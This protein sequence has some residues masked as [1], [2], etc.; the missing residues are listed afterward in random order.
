MHRVGTWAGLAGMLAGVFAVV[1]ASGRVVGAQ[2]L[3]RLRG[4][5]GVEAYLAMQ[6][7]RR[8]GPVFVSGAISPLWAA[9]SRSLTYWSG[10]KHH[11]FD[12]D[13]R[14]DTVVPDGAGPDAGSV[15]AGGGAGDPVPTRPVPLPCPITIVDRGRQRPCEGSPDL[16]RRAYSRDR[17]LYI[18]AADGSGEV[19]VTTDGSEAGRVKYG[20]ASWVYGEE[21]DQ[22]T[23]I[24]WS[25]DSSKVAFYRFDE[26]RVQDYFLALDQTRLQTR[27]DVEAYPK[28]GTANPVVDVLVYD[29]ATH[30]TVRL[31]VRD[32]QPFSDAVVGHYVYGVTWSAD[33]REVRLFRTDRRQQHWEYAGCS[34][35]SGR[36]RVIA[37]EVSTTGWVENRPTMRRLADGHRFLLASERT[38]WRNY[39]LYDDRRGFIGPVTQLAGSEAGDI[40]RVDEA[41]GRLYYMARDGDDFLKLQLHRVGLD[42]RDDV[43]LTDPRCTH[44]VTLAPDGRSFVD[45]YQTHAAA[46][47]SRVVDMDGHVIAELAHSDLSRFD[48]LGLRPVEQFPYVAGDGRTHLFGTIS[49]PSGYDP[50]RRYP[51]LVSVYAGPEST[52]GV[53]SETFTPPSSM[54]E[55]GFLVVTFGTRAQPGLGRRTLDALYLHLGQTEI[56]DLAAGVRVLRQRPDVEP[57]RIGIYGTSYGGYAALMALLRYPNLFAA[58]SVS[59]APTDWRQYDTIYTERYMWTPQGNEAGYEAA[60]ALTYAGNLRGRLLIY[61]GTADNNVHPGNSLDLM[62]ALNRAGKSY[63][64]QIGPDQEHSSVP[65]E[66]MMEFFLENLVVRPDR[67]FATPGDAPVARAVSHP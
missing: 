63:E 36:C 16:T 57:D 35:A 56:D 1:T 19:A 34:P 2:T 18:S 39:D 37:R 61:Y 11:R 59:S 27:V 65:T 43:R 42:G 50:A 48:A 22:T 40:V 26:S 21:L 13:T 51:V 9:D 45:V 62:E 31:D 38:G 10:G 8:D 54:S 44:D 24:W 47:A 55:Y 46:P 7:E 67:L 30:R 52:A 60:S 49:F 66:R 6:R 53:P 15:A 25:P 12:L 5:P 3:D 29:L 41:A 33:G 28:A 64:V 58:A 17:N 32:G 14:A 20:V 4:M 23:A